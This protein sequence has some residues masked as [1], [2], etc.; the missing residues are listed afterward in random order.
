MIVF[1]G[2]S[3]DTGVRRGETGAVSRWRLRL[4]RVQ[5]PFFLMIRRPPRSTLFPYTTLFRSGGNAG[6]IEA[7]GSLVAV[8][9]FGSQN[10]SIFER[11]NRSL[12]MTQSVP[13]ASNP[14]SVA[15]GGSHLYILG[16]TKVES[17]TMYG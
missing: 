17:H 2:R 8:V 5:T 4:R 6:G 10:V 14:V 12:R 9:N 16:T 1:Q 13:A 7:K 11:A 15:F 3:Q